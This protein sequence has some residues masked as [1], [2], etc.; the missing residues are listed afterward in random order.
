MPYSTGGEKSARPT[1]RV[2]PRS[3]YE[4]MEQQATSKPPPK[5]VT[6][7]IQELQLYYQRQEQRASVAQRSLER[8]SSAIGRPWFLGLVALL[9]LGWNRW[10]L[11]APS[12]HQPTF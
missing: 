4:D 12:L 5:S 10:N 1:D 3:S 6:E 11:L 2:R 9:V 7:N 8:F